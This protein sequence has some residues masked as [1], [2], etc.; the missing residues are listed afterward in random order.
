MVVRKSKNLDRLLRLVPI[1]L[2]SAVIV[3]VVPYRELVQALAQVSLVDVLWLGL[4]SAGLIGVSALK[5]RA[6]LRQMG[7]SQSFVR[8][9]SFYLVGYFVNTFSPSFI[10]GDVVRSLMVGER[11][12]RARAIAATFLER[13]TGIV[14]MLFMA[15]LACLIGVPVSAEIIVAVILASFACVS[16]TVVVHYR[17]Y[18][19]LMRVC[20]LPVRFIKAL[21][22]FQEGLSLGIRDRRLFAKALLMSLLFH[23]LTIVNTAVVGI[24][25]GWNDFSLGALAAVVPLILV[26]GAVP[27][28]PQG[29]GIQEGAFV[30]FLTQVGATPAQALAVG[31]VLRAKSIVL[32][33]L[34]GFVC[35]RSPKLY[36]IKNRGG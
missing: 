20:K 29:L 6:F 26:V 32:A 27:I 3:Y 1:L 21:E 5:W 25:V 19:V 14:S 12:E 16:A 30:Y 17:W 18:I 23:L 8:L 24:A 35:V 2:A 31:V 36:S 34:G 10:G 11:V 15:N 28:S 9:F 33:C 4:I 7:I 22:A 13:Y